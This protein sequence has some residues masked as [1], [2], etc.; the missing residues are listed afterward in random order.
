MRGA[1]TASSLLATLLIWPLLV[2]AWGCFKPSPYSIAERYIDNLK[3]N[4]YAKCYALLS[5]KDRADRPIRQFL[6][7]IPLAPDVSPIWFE[8]ILRVTRFK[9]GNEHRNSDGSAYVSVRVTAPDLPRW[10]RLLDSDAGGNVPISRLVEHSLAT[11]TYPRISYEDR[12]VLIKENHYWRVMVGFEARDRVLQGYRQAL[13][14]FYAGRLDQA[15]AQFSTLIREL[16]QIPGTGNLGIAARLSFQVAI[17]QRLKAEEGNLAAYR[18]KLKLD[19]VAMRMAAARVPAIFGS[20]TNAGNRPIDELRMAVTWYQGR[21]NSLRV[22]YREEH[23][24]IVTPIQFT[25]FTRRVVP[26]LPGEKRQFGFILSAPIE[27][28][29]N[30]TPRVSIASLAFSEIPATLP[31]RETASVSVAGG[32][33]PARGLSPT[34]SLKPNGL[35]LSPGDQHREVP[36][37][38]AG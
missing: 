18:T 11:G 8:R 21:G 27:V 34:P 26:F 2:G 9:L 25:D 37:E 22:V 16:R 33:Q 14:D 6:T 5:A 31:S 4:K 30:A 36:S 1:T 15:I 13:N 35:S 7:E 32:G 29:Q 3:Q 17:L 24:I 28:Q 20:I 38:P 23:A 19:R 12:I 10:E